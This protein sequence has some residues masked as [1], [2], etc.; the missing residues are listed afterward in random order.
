MI[1]VILSAFIFVAYV[2]WAFWKC[3]ITT[4]LSE[5]HYN[6]PRWMFPI[7]MI[8]MAVLALPYWLEYNEDWQFLAFFSCAGIILL[9]A[10][11][12]FKR[13]DRIIHISSVCVAGISAF[14]W[15]LLINWIVTCLLAIIMCGLALNYR[16]YWGLIMEIT[17]FVCVYFILLVL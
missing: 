12:L 8:S 4:T 5:T 7:A 10:A 6:L 16:K 15:C 14:V 11:P 2:M 9:G 3:G 17:M 1:G 13:E